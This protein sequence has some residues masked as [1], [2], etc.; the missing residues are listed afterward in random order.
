MGRKNRFLQR[1]MADR[2]GA[3]Q[4]S[5]FLAVTAVIFML[6]AFL[7]RNFHAAI[8]FEIIMG[9]LLLFNTFRMLS[10]NKIKRIRENAVFLRMRD[11]FL[12][13]WK[14]YWRKM[15][16]WFRGLKPKKKRKKKSPDPGN[17]SGG[18]GTA[19]DSA[20][21]SDYKANDFSNRKAKHVGGTDYDED[22]SQEGSI[23]Y[24]LFPCPGCNAEVRVPGNKGRILIRCPRC[25]TEFE[26]VS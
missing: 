7:S 6:L 12:F 4:L 22:A 14:A 9:L 15:G 25:G 13:H 2:Y 1:F 8:V 10:K 26:R 3:D 24:C 19:G 18:G 5:G 17:I 20:D 16:A 21:F 11:R 23:K